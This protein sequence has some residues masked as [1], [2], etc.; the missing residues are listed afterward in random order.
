MVPD[1]TARRR[2][3]HRMMRRHMTD[4]AAHGRPLQTS[5][6]TTDARQHANQSGECNTQL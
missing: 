6:R 3:E 5:F 2:A 1:D 4:H